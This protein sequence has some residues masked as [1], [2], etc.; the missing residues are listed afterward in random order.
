MD[1]LQPLTI[2]HPMVGAVGAVLRFIRYE[3]FEIPFIATHRKDYFHP[4]LTL[5]QL[6]RVYDLDEKFLTIE[7]KKKALKA[8]FQDICRVS[9]IAAGNDYALD[10]I[11][12]VTTLDEIA[13]MQLYL[14]IHYGTE[15]AETSKQRLYKKPTWRVAYEGAKRNNLDQ[16]AKV[17]KEHFF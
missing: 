1:D 16:L 7:V 11:E 3:H 17:S 5:D 10:H 14:Q 9:P 12:K 15:L 8:S 4:L 13:D 2:E 6:W